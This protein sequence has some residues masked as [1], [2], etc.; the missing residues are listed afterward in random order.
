[1]R[2]STKFLIFSLLIETNFLCVIQFPNQLHFV[3][4]TGILHDP[5]RFFF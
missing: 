3:L 5:K 4:F 2:S 1:M